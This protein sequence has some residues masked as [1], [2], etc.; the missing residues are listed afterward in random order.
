MRT[1]LRQLIL[2]VLIIAGLGL[3]VPSTAGAQFD[4][5]QSL[6][7]P[8]RAAPQVFKGDANLN[9]A[10]EAARRGDTAESLKLT[11]E[12]MAVRGSQTS[13]HDPLSAQ[14]AAKLVTLSE[15][16]EEHEAH[17]ADVAALLQEIVLPKGKLAE[18]WP[19][20]VTWQPSHRP[21]SPQESRYPEPQSVAA[22][23]VKWSSRAEVLPQINDR[24]KT[25]QASLHPQIDVFTVQLAVAQSDSQ[26][27]NQSLK[28]LKAAPLAEPTLQEWA[29]HAVSAGCR[30]PETRTAAWELL[31]ALLNSVDP[32]QPTLLNE[33][34]FAFQLSAAQG[35][36]AV[37]RPEDA[38]RLARA[39]AT[40]PLAQQR[41]GSEMA[42]YVAQ[43]QHSQAAATLLQGHRA[44]EALELLSKVTDNPRSQYEMYYPAPNVTA[45]LG[46]ELAALPPEKRFEL[47]AEWTLP[48]ESPERFRSLQEFVPART[49]ISTAEPPLDADPI[50]ASGVFRNVYST[51]WHLFITAK[52]LNRLD[53]FIADLA[54][55]PKDQPD[56][57]ALNLLA[58]LVRDSDSADATRRLQLQQRLR[59]L[60][61]LTTANVP[62]WEDNPKRPLSMVSCVV[63]LEAAKSPALTEMSQE[64]L[65]RLIEHT[66]RLQWDRPRPHL[67][68][69]W[70]EMLRRRSNP[71]PSPSGSLPTASI[72]S[73]WQDLQPKNWIA[74][75]AES[76]ARQVN[77][78]L[79]DVWLAQDESIEHLT[80]RYDSTLIFQHPL[81]GDFEFHAEVSEGAWSEGAI[82]YGGTYFATNGYADGAPLFAPGRT[83]S[84]WSPSLVNLLH[85]NPWNRQ[86]VEVRDGI[87]RYY[88]NGQF[89]YEDEHGV[90]APWLAL[91][92]D[93]GR[94]PIYRNL[95]FT[96]SP[97][98]PREVALLSDQRLRGWMTQFYDETQDDPLQPKRQNARLYRTRQ[99]LTFPVTITAE[100][101]QSEVPRQ[102]A[103]LTDWYFDKNELRSPRRSDVLGRPIP[104]CIKYYRPVQP[105]ESVTYEFFSKSGEFL[106]HPCIGRMILD[107]SPRK[108]T[109]RPMNTGNLDIRGD[110]ES[111]HDFAHA[112]E[113]I[114]EGWNT[115][116]M[117]MH[118][119]H[120]EI[121][122]NQGQPL[123]L[124][125]AKPHDRSFGFWH[126][127]AQTTVR[128]RN[129]VLRGPWPEAFSQAHQAAIER[130]QPVN[131]P[132]SRTFVNDVI[133]EK[134]LASNAYGVYQRA[135]QLDGEARY[136]F[137]YRW[138]MPGPDHP[139]L[140]TMGALTPTHPSPPALAE[141]PIDVA[142]AEIRQSIDGRRVQTGG[143]FVCP[144]VLLLF[145]ALELGRLGDISDALD[146]LPVSVT[147]GQMRARTAMHGM[148]ALLED[149]VDHA[150][151]A[152]WDSNQL[153]VEAG[154]VEQHE[155]WSEPAFCSLAILHPETRDVA[156]ELLD[157]IQ[158]RQ[159]QSGQPGSN[160]FNRYVRYLHGQALYLQQGGV[161]ENFGTNPLLK[162]W[163]SVS[164]PCARTRGA[165]VPPAAFDHLNHEWN[166]RG[167]HDLDMLYF[168]SPL[169]GDFELRARLSQFDYRELMPLVGGVASVV[170]FDGKSKKLQ[171]IRTPLQELPL[172]QAHSNRAKAF[173]DYHVVVK[174]GH[175]TVLVNGQK[176]HE[177]PLPLQR[178]PWL[179][180]QGWAGQ[181]SR[182]ARH[183]VITGT[184]EIP[185]ELDLLA[186][187]D[188]QGWLADNYGGSTGQA[189][190]PWKRDQDELIC[191]QSVIRGATPGRLKVENIL[192]Y[193][194][195][196]MEDGEIS[197]E[198]F[199]DPDAKVAE[200][201]DNQQQV[202]TAANTNWLP[203]QVSVHPALDR[204]V[205]MLEPGG[206]KLHWLTDGK[207][208]RTRVSPGNMAPL[209]SKKPLL[210]KKQEWNAVR[211]QVRGD[212]LTLVLNGETVLRH[213]IEP[214]NQ[215]HFGF[216]HFVNEST[217]RVRQVKYRGDWPLQ[218]PKVVNQEL[219]QGPETAL[220]NLEQSLSARR[221]YDMAKTPLDVD[222]FSYLWDSKVTRF[223]KPTPQGLRMTFPAGEQKGTTVAGFAPRVKVKG[224]FIATLDYEQLSTVPVKEAWGSGLTFRIKLTGSYDAGIEVR[225]TTTG[226]V[227]SC[228]WQMPTPSKTPIYYSE[229][230][231]E[232][233]TEG[234]LRLA[235][236]GNLLYFLV[237]E[238]RSEDFRLLTT[239]ALGTMDLERVGAQVDCSDAAGGAD[240]IVKRLSIQAQ[241]LVG[242]K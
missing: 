187:P 7:G 141:N 227:L 108:V 128:V 197:Y 115:V 241:E 94:T 20:P 186:P 60:V 172:E 103:I 202:F 201:R 112:S 129:V 160:E 85:R 183:V 165:G 18:F 145:S 10:Y 158:R 234:R 221:D 119:D 76:A 49:I 41:Y 75:G 99:S 77:G 48:K 21:W 55:L 180:L 135:L 34:R 138:V 29:L 95:K 57:V 139:T 163:Q 130:P 27:A 39:A 24:L 69:A 5:L 74:S 231:S 206:V 56:V 73:V 13:R 117:T 200:P 238:P 192:R 51:A 137:L 9:A 217:A 106:T 171:S 169:Q 109:L 114:E 30:L 15:V 149:R 43:L 211:V 205:L 102:I 213:P 32:S 215:R 219:A 101:G 93:W 193:H 134:D 65:L 68:M 198:F 220:I 223:F 225:R 164:Q 23:L 194:R 104:S 4:F 42:E 175:L 126:D 190:Y 156:W 142:T 147:P 181:S 83:H 17:P 81:T 92:S 2:P 33:C 123:K 148:I 46:R 235:R 150:R 40:L 80:G 236:N 207:Y 136:Q 204:M 82:S 146:Q 189:L 174:N 78:T 125:L 179:A 11:R 199:Y 71:G 3:G 212:E 154:S 38:I 120:I 45:L 242:P 31:E 132:V 118:A 62:K 222:K 54:R 182:V 22:E 90:S 105:G 127:A 53:A 6:F 79:P 176:L 91:S 47:L 157:R 44:A 72:P 214:T 196:M 151:S 58:L 195:P 232:F 97:Q 1:S 240:V 233:P 111:A 66:Q 67:R 59:I 89:I 121:V 178:D 113:W 19:Y 191:P 107:L 36:F 177:Q 143:S 237:A 185:R 86:K 218:L 52:E 159:L 173:G 162:Q 110:D 14:I 98:I 70:A 208:D 26:T 133:G 167:G 224:D 100:D 63:A 153:L 8:R 122:I 188:L 168:Q 61:E 230:F 239:R 87:V 216:F 229:S 88:A 161:P 166:L 16:W 35:F 152:L 210:L 124:P 116:G 170:R 37:D 131:P 64:L 184:P 84:Q 155:R 28:L 144:A 203:G 226:T 12:A 25:A 228:V 140:R 209:D 96:G 50:P